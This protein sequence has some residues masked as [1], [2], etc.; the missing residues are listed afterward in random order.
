[1]IYPQQAGVNNSFHHMS[2]T[3]IRS[4][5]PR[6][7]EIIPKTFLCLLKAKIPPA[8]SATG[9]MSIAKNNPNISSVSGSNNQCKKF[10]AI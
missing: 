6:I 5:V 8:I 4:S 10:L 9:I 2:I 1:M 7:I 3:T